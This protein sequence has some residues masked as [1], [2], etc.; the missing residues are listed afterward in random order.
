MPVFKTAE[1]IRAF[2]HIFYVFAVIILG[3]YVYICYKE[4]KIEKIQRNHLSTTQRPNSYLRSANDIEL[5]P[6]RSGW[7]SKNLRYN[8]PYL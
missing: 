1:Q 5:K 3:L 7:Q 8:E 4:S 6:I 2:L